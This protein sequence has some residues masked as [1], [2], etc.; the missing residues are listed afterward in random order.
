[1]LTKFEKV[2]IVLKDFE[3]GRLEMLH[4][5]RAIVDTKVDANM[6]KIALVDIAILLGCFYD[7]YIGVDVSEEY[8]TITQK[9]IALYKLE[10]AYDYLEG[11]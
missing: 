8:D 7:N 10:G 1:M 9:I 5:L 4:E 6:E 2:R 3:I 11:A